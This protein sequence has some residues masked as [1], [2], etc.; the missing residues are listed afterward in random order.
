MREFK[1]GREIEREF[2]F[3]EEAEFTQ[4]LREA[5]F[6]VIACEGGTGGTTGGAT[7]QW[8]NVFAEVVK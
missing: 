2:T 6:R 3:W 8:L 4:V 7:T 5:V 1:Y